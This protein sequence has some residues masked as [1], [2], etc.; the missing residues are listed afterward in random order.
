MTINGL[1][2]PTA[3][4]TSAATLKPTYT[5]S[6]HPS[7]PIDDSVMAL[8]C[9]LD[10]PSAKMAT[11]GS[12]EESSLSTHHGHVMSPAP[13]DGDGDDVHQPEQ[14]HDSHS[15][16]DLAKESKPQQISSY[17]APPTPSPDTPV[18]PKAMPQS[19][20]K[21]CRQL[22]SSIQKHSAAWPFLQPVDPVAVGAPDYFRIIAQPMDLST[23]ER[24]LGSRDYDTVD[25]F[26]SDLKL[27]ISNC[28]TYNPPTH[29]VHQLAK[30][31]EGYVATQLTKMF[32][33]IDLGLEESSPTAAGRRRRDIKPPR[34][35]EPEEDLPQKKAKVHRKSS[36]AEDVDAAEK[37][38]KRRASA[39]A[40]DASYE[41][42]EIYESKISNL[43]ASIG[44][45]QAQLADLRRKSTSLKS[46]RSVSPESTPVPKKQR[47]SKVESPS[48]TPSPMSSSSVDSPYPEVAAAAGPM[49][50]CENCG[51]STTPMWRRGPSGKST[52]CNRCGVKWRSGKLVV[53]EDGVTM[54]P[55]YVPEPGSRRASGP[56][57]GKKRGPRKPKEPVSLPAR[58]ITYTQKK[59]LSNMITTLS[60]KAMAGVV[61]IIRAGHPDIGNGENE[62]EIDID[63][64]EPFTLARLYDYVLKSCGKGES[65]FSYAPASRPTKAPRQPRK[66]S[67]N[68]H[69]PVPVKPSSLAAA[70][71]D[72][73]DSDDF[74]SGSDLD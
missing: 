18:P 41:V 28:I 35:F 47:K 39:M 11:E 21:T 65:L 69:A 14:H 17:S 6:G 52:L 10:V 31:L 12:R 16:S 60:E 44:D 73:S 57:A 67:S 25:S 72:D 51:T 56:T 58:Q 27:M 54:L 45:I 9:L 4:D 46:K 66:N 26:A 49:K 42:E 24:K 5:S 74:M 33:A 2:L 43:V 59:E 8:D 63:S 22:L 40:D 29:S 61:D 55:P 13:T 70:L 48:R 7:P 64:I 30:V 32:P 15:P 1:L 37:G 19:E 62:I 23:I 38:K 53:G 3:I 68:I 34:V 71:D 50:E 20:A 36:V